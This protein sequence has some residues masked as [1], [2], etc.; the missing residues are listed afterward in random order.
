M[1]HR[2]L[3]DEQ[4]A[5]RLTV[6]DYR[7]AG[8]YVA[9]QRAV[10]SMT[11]GQVI[12]EV[13]SAGLRGRGGAGVLTAEKLGLVAQR[14]GEI[15][16]VVCNAYDADARSQ[17]SHTL[18]SRDPHRV[19]EGLAL[20]AYAVGASEAY[21]YMR[22]SPESVASSVREALRDAI[23]QRIIGRD[24]LGSRVSVAITVVGVDLGF[25]AGEETTMLE[26]IKG[27]RAMPQQRP[28]YPTQFGLNDQPTLV[29]NIETAAN[30]P[31]IVARGGEAFQRVGA[32]GDPGTKLFTVCGPGLEGGHLIEVPLGTPIAQA[33]KAAGIQATEA[34][35]R[36]VVVGG[37]EGGVLP[38]SLLNT[39]LT[40]DALDAAGVLV[41]SSVLE[42]LPVETCLV[43]WAARCSAALSRE[44]CGKC[45]P[46]R[47]GVKRIA[48]TLEGLV[49]DLGSANDLT[50]LQD[51]AT[52]VPDGSLCGFGVHAVHPVVTAMKY[53]ADD[54][55]A[56]LEG[57]CPT[58]TCQP[59]RAH[60]FATK[61]VL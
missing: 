56:H 58:G 8:G 38:L 23:D 49:S 26:V 18:L 46:C 5:P 27:K 61:H 7:R 22:G 12:G 6:E 57:R 37:L 55:Q 60:R 11:R 40:F 39:P 48:G 32:A 13:R 53:F 33:L 47:V 45:V 4:E 3:A 36:G 21:L 19:I 35:S 24:L 2:L 28:P 59:V 43:A 17:I 31:Q 10:T 9:L 29:L 54:F 41:G 15:P 44:S 42:V 34:N 16:S 30:L 51:L 14:E 50:L 52:Y 25:M 20:A 1:E